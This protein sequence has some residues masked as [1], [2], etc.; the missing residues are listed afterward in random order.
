MDRMLPSAWMPSLSLL[1]A[2]LAQGIDRAL[3]AVVPVSCSRPHLF[4]EE[5]GGSVVPNRGGIHGQAQGV[6]WPAWYRAG[7]EERQ[8]RV[9]G[10]LRHGPGSCLC[11]GGRVLYS[12]G[13]GA[14]GEGARGG[15][16]E[17]CPQDFLV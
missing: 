1:A 17:S 7:L 13:A 6:G 5:K 8:Q 3:C 16:L 11:P 14:M 12:D 15:T 4:G 9:R 10:G 2:T